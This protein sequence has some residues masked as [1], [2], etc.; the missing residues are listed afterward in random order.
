[1]VAVKFNF[2]VV[3]YSSTSLSTIGDFLLLIA[4]T[5]FESISTAYTLLC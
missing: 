5:L 4:L 2:F 1:M 3:R